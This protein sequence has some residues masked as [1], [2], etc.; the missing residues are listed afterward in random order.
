MAELWTRCEQAEHSFSEASIVVPDQTKGTHANRL[1]ISVPG[2][3]E[4]RCGKERRTREGII[5]PAGNLEGG[6]KDLGAYKFCHGDRKSS[7]SRVSAVV[8]GGVALG[9]RLSVTAGDNENQRSGYSTVWCLDCADP[10][11]F[12]RDAVNQQ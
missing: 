11:G 7:K 4:P 10:N 8:A 6:T 12:F 2:L 9:T 3:C 1:K 5:L